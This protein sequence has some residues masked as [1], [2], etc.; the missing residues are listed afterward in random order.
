M[1]AE[2]RMQNA[3]EDLAGLRS[4]F[5]VPSQSVGAK[6]LR[7]IGLAWLSS[8]PLVS[9]FRGYFLAQSMQ[10]VTPGRAANLAAGMGEPHRLQRFVADFPVFGISVKL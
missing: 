7:L 9:T 6:P 8:T 10:V 3:E 4:A 2:C 1:N 5:C